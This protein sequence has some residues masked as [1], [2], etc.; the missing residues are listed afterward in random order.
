MTI[1]TRLLLL[2]TI[3]CYT[4]STYGQKLKEN[5]LEAAS[6]VLAKIG[7]GYDV[8]MADLADRFGNKLNFHLGIERLSA[9][10]WIVSADFTYRFGSDVREDVLAGFRL[11]Y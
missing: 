10:N 9:S 1:L 2:I 8:P 3:F 6:K 11:E 5:R 4:T 7:M